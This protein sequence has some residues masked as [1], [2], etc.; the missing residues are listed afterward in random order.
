MKNTNNMSNRQQ[1]WLQI[2]NRSS[3]ADFRYIPVVHN[4][5]SQNFQKPRSIDRLYTEI[6]PTETDVFENG[7]QLA[8]SF[9]HVTQPHPHKLAQM[10]YC[11]TTNQIANQMTN[12]MNGSQMMSTNQITCNNSNVDWFHQNSFKIGNFREDSGVHTAQNSSDSASSDRYSDRNSPILAI[13]ESKSL[14]PNQKGSKFDLTNHM[15]GSKYDLTNQKSSNRNSAL[16][17]EQSDIH[18]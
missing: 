10:S 16:I 2:D 8:Q 18:V 15:Q 3:L 9:G 4:I 7:S 14:L 5:H 11:Q 1:N 6:V 13:E 12:Q 17:P